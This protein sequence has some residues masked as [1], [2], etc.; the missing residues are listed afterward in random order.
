MRACTIT[1]AVAIA[2]LGS[3]GLAAQ[4]S[5]A[6]A[7]VGAANKKFVDAFARKDAKAIAALYTAEAEAFPPNGP[8]VRGRAEIE[9][10][11]QSVVTSGVA[12]ATLTTAEVES[13]GDLAYETGSF[14]MKTADGKVADQG[15]YVVV[16]KRVGGAWMLH[17]DIWN[18]NQPA[19]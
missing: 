19:K 8:V 16:W 5:S 12:S 15:K 7:A 3:I 14:E 4:D 10:M 18:T 9:K 17:R 6:R 13:A 2:V 1:L 11:W